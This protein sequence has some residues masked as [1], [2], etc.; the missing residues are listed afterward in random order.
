MRFELEDR[1]V[2]LGEVKF[3]AGRAFY[4]R[5]IGLQRVDLCAL[6]SLGRFKPF[7]LLVEPAYILLH[8]M[9]AAEQGKEQQR[10]P[11]RHHKNKDSESKRLNSLP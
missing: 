7:D 3:V 9:A 1:L 5:G 6:P 8:E 11:D 2:W 4:E 10:H